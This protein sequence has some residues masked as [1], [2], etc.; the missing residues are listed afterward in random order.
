MKI[1]VGDKLFVPY[2][3]KNLRMMVVS[4]SNRKIIAVVS[5]TLYSQ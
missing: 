5:E 3:E 4:K 2:I 1:H